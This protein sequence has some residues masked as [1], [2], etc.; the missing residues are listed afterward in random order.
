MFGFL[1]KK[2]PKVH[3]KKVRPPTPPLPAIDVKDVNGKPRKLQFVP[4]R[5]SSFEQI[6]GDGI[7]FRTLEVTRHLPAVACNNILCYLEFVDPKG[8][9][10]PGSKLKFHPKYTGRMILRR[11]EHMY[12]GHTAIAKGFI[13]LYLDLANVCDEDMERVNQHRDRIVKGFN[14]E[15]REEFFPNIF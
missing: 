10:K 12:H 1:K 14:E 5:A 8:L 7:N 6:Q 3:S 2:Q 15:C 9:A 11:I 13:V 4:C